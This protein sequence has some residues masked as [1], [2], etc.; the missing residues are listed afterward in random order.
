MSKLSRR[1]FLKL[2]GLALG[3]SALSGGAGYAW[4]SNTL[5]V[6]RYHRR[7][8]GL[9][10]PLR[11]G[12]LTDF[13]AP[14]YRF[15]LEKL[16]EILNTARC[17]WIF[18]VGD[19]V[20]R[21]GNEPQVLRLFRELQAQQGKLAS[22]GNWEYMGHVDLIKL[23]RLY[24]E[25]DVQLLINEEIAVSIPGDERTLHIIG[26]DDYLMG[27]P[28]YS[29]LPREGP[30]IVLS[31]CPAP[32]DRIAERGK[33]PALVLSGHTHGGQIAPFGLVLYL[34]P[35]SGRFVTGWYELPNGSLLYVSPG[36]GNSGLPFRVGVRPTL[37]ILEVS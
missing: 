5:T 26:L 35:G 13:H 2:G 25:A 23:R 36:L 7:I 34:P 29:L 10:Q 8:W 22:L 28:N 37:A 3:L 11:L 33:G 15:P 32:A 14:N 19:T 12:V 6:K 4:W 20:D 24:A 18:I 27:A 1:R 16:V 21:G 30:T 9:N 31:H 17:D